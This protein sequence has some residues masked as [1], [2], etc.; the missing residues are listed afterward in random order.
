MGAGLGIGVMAEEV[1]NTLDGIECAFPTLDAVA[2]PMWLVTHREVRTSRR[3]RL[4]FD[5]L[6]ET[7]GRRS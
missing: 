5:V 6:A 2:V 7:L 4:V 1:A 3:I